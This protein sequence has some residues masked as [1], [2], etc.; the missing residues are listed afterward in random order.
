VVERL[1]AIPRRGER[2]LEV[3]LHLLLAD[4]LAEELGAEGKLGLEI[5]LDG[6]RGKDS[7]VYS[8]VRDH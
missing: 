8:L 5:V 4:V 7:L 2:D 6:L 1:A 3:R